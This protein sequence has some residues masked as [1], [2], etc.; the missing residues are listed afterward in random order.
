MRACMLGL[1]GCVQLFVTLMDCGPPGSSVHG[2]LQA[3][4]PEWVPMPFSRGSSR[5]SDWARVSCIAGGFFRVWPTREDRVPVKLNLKNRQKSR[6]TPGWS[7]ADPCYS[8][9]GF[10]GGSGI[11]NPPA[12]QEMQETWVPTLGWGEPLEEEMTTC[13][14]ILAWKISWTE[15]PGG[16]QSRG[17]QRVGYNRTTEHTPLELDSTVCYVFKFLNSEKSYPLDF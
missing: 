13:S 4:I 10:P 11:K 7:F 6:F 16:L 17:L 15:E 8:H 2:I 14:R 3:R 12:M 1:F 5:P 9:G